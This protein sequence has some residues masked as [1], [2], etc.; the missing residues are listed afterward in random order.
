MCVL[1]CVHVGAELCACVCVCVCVRERRVCVCA[2]MRACV[3]QVLRAAQILLFSVKA[4]DVL[5]QGR[6]GEVT[7]MNRRNRQFCD[8]VRRDHA[9][10]LTLGT[11]FHFL[12]VLR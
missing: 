1:N 8:G 10:G 7:A 5:G 12:W 3:F 6:L 9:G 4:G 2:C 11:L